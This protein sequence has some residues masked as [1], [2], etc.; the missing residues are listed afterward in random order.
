MLVNL[1]GMPSIHCTYHDAHTIII[2]SDVTSE[3]SEV[4][5]Q[6][7]HEKKGGKGEFI[8]RVAI[9]I[10][11]LKDYQSLW[12][13]DG[14]ANT[15]LMNRYPLLGKNNEKAKGELH[16]I[17]KCMRTGDAEVSYQDFD[18]LKVVCVASSNVC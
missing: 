10:S 4:V 18:L 8:G 11:T 5:V 7:Y 12:Y 3:E 1:N 13:G 15:T 6:L 16:I 14:D 2:I 17:I 9:N